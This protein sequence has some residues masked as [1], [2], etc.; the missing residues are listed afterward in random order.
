MIQ[1][2]L[3]ILCPI[4]APPKIICRWKKQGDDRLLILQTTD[5]HPVRK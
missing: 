2:V 4:I 3:V 1:F 5:P